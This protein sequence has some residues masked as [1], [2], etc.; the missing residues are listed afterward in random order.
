MIF[1]MQKDLDAYVCERVTFAQ[2]LFWITSTRLRSTLGPSY[3]SAALIRDFF[4]FV[5]TNAHLGQM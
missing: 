3:D 1:S 5:N 2:I 4:H